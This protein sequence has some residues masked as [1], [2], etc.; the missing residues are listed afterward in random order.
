MGVSDDGISGARE[1]PS[2]WW[3]FIANAKDPD[4]PDYARH[5]ERLVEGYWR[6]IYW[7]IR[8]A[9]G[10]GHDDAKD[11]T[12]DFFAIVV[13]DRDLVKR[14]APE[15]GSFRALLRAALSH[16]MT[17]VVR[18]GTAQKRGAGILPISMDAVADAD[19]LARPGVASLTPEDLFDAAWNQNVMNRAASLLGDRLRAEGRGAA[20]EAF[21]RY[22]LEGDSAEMSHGDLGAELGLTAHQVKHALVY[23]RGA[24]REVVVEVVRTYV[25]QPSDVAAEIEALL[26]R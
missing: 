7:V 8:H 24:F 16:Y 10:K 15:R 12:Q 5:M 3:S 22:Y 11:L 25:D 23:A 6:P 1:F 4:S 19:L 17:D 26:G 20:F 2:T 9:W 13:F 21:R 14:W 18:G